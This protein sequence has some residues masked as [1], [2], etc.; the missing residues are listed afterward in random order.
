MAL[1][2]ILRK[3]IRFRWGITF[4]FGLIHGLGFADLLKEMALPK[5]QLA[6]A[7]FS[8]NIGIEVIQIGIVLLCLPILFYLHKWKDSLKM[9]QYLS[10]I[11][12]AAG[13]YFLINQLF[14]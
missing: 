14:F 9:I 11:I 12:V 13:V 5:S 3:K 6:V 1:E 10:W 2:N 7:L 4:A 8:F